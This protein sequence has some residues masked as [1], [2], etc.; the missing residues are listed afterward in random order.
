MARIVVMYIFFLSLGSHNKNRKLNL[1]FPSPPSSILK[2][3]YIHKI[4][5]KKIIPRP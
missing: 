3:V 2:I 5:K 4:E 1:P